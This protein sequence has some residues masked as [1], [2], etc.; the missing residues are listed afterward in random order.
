M[1]ANTPTESITE[2][3]FDL[4]DWINTGTVARRQVV[5]YTDHEAYAQA[6]RI[7]D[8]LAELG[9]TERDDDRPQD[10]PLSEGIGPDDDEVAALEAELESW[11]ARLDK[12]RMTWTVRAVSKDEITAAADAN[13]EP[14]M[15]PPPKDGAPAAVQERWM[16]RVQ[17]YNRAKRVRDEVV[18]LAVVA[19]A[20]VSIETPAGTQDGVTVDQLRALQGRPHGAQWVERLYKAVEQATD[21]NVAPPVPTSPARFTS[22]RG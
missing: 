16:E 15:P 19:A 5:I 1:P 11:S 17:A 10:G 6:V 4:L 20:V 9:W 22:T 3:A 7:T 18:N 2:D 14:K 12:S 21:E 13:P 8:R